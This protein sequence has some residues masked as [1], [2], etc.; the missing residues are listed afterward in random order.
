LKDAI[1]I[2]ES[3]G[4]KETVADEE[5]IKENLILYSVV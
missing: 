2:L 4:I 5:S 1:Q 3:I